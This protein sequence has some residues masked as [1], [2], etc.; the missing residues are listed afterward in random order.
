MHIAVWSHSQIDQKQL[1]LKQ[2]KPYS[3]HDIHVLFE[4]GFYW[5]FSRRDEVCLHDVTLQTAATRNASVDT[6]EPN[7]C[8]AH[9]AILRACHGFGK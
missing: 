8:A 7:N 2:G 5:K 4:H 9:E 6:L 1:V 3:N